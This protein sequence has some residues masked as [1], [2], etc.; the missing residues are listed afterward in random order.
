MW[1]R[2][3]KESGE[4]GKRGEGKGEK[5]EEVEGGGRWRGEGESKGKGAGA[6]VGGEK[7]MHM[8]AGKEHE[9]KRRRVGKGESTEEERGIEMLGSREGIRGR[10]Q[11]N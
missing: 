2:R 9:W 6:E 5:H 7:Y 3:S 11:W 8:S 1:G 4:D 10:K